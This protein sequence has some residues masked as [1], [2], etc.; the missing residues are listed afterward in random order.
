M[1]VLPLAEPANAIWLPSA[2]SDG[3]AFSSRPVEI[4]R[5]SPPSRPIVQI[6]GKRR[7]YDVYATRP[8]PAEG[9]IEMDLWEVRLRTLRPSKSSAATSFV[10]PCSTTQRIVDRNRPGLPVKYLTRSF[11]SV[12]AMRST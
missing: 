12:C 2:E 3:D 11:A 1:S 7:T 8:P 9:E 10:P 5:L 4:S 6:W